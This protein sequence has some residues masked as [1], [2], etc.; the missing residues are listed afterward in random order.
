MYAILAWLA[1]W[2]PTILICLGL[3]A[4]VSLLIYSLIRDKKK[5]KSSCG[6]GCGC[7]GC[8]MSGQCH[9]APTSS[10]K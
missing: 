1:A 9:S 3:V 8:P 5:G 10:D 6:C 4:L 2:W 7:S